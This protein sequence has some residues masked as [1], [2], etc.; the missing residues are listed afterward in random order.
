MNALVIAHIAGGSLAILSGSVAAAARKGGRSHAVAGSWFFGSMLVLGAS[1]ALL[2]LMLAVPDLVR[3]T[4][5]TFTIYLVTTS[6]AAARWKDGMPGRLDRVACCI[7]LGLAIAFAALAVA[8]R[9]SSGP[10]AGSGVA[11]YLVL[12]TV[13]AL[14]GALDLNV[15]VR[16]SVSGKQRI[17]RHLWRM[18]LALFF[19]TAS[20]FLGQQKVMP[21]S[22]RGSL[23]L[24]VLGLAPLGVMAFWLVRIR[25]AKPLRTP[26]L[27]ALLLGQPLAAR[28]K[29]ER[30]GPISRAPILKT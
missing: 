4:G 8:A 14:W 27:K 3:V 28:S 23:L 21:P 7:I 26:I 20:F 30:R 18:C 29:V 25:F 24:W 11:F 6:W 5:G 13:C 16:Q 12:A 17:Y 19:A 22:I 2:A 9:M 15:I 10:I 1:A